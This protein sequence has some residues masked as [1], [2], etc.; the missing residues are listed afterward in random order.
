MTRA[1]GAVAVVVGGVSGSGKTTIGRALAERL[2]WPFH[3][4]DDLHSAESLVRMQRG[5][6]L[7]DA[8]RAPWLQRVR[9]QIE[10]AAQEQRPVVIACSALKADYRA[11]LARDLAGV[12]FVFL[13]VPR[14]VLQARLAARAGHFFNPDLLDDQLAVLEPP[15]DALTVDATRPVPEIVE[16]I[17]SRLHLPA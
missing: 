15:P 2:R 9:A 4:A 3:D 10:L 13:S 6:P 14:P 5:L 8:L 16:T 17:V 11:A 12:R 1:N 7:N